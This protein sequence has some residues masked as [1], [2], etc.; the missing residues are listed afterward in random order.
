MLFTVYL[1]G[2][3]A[4]AI[5]TRHFLATVAAAY[6]VPVT[7][8]DAV[9]GLLGSR[10]VVAYAVLPVATWC[11]VR[12]LQDEARHD[13]LVRYAT[14]TDWAFGQGRRALSWIGLLVGALVC[15]AL[16]SGVG[17]PFGW[18]WS[19]A[20]LE[21]EIVRQLPEIGARLPLP[22]LGVALHALALV[23]TLVALTILAAGPASKLA[24]PSVLIG[25]PVAV[26]L[27]AM[28]SS[29]T[30][31]WVAAVLGPLTYA[32]PMRAALLLPF[33]VGGGVIIL[34]VALLLGY[35]LL[36]A[37]EMREPRREGVPWVASCF[38]AGCATLLAVAALMPPGE[39]GSVASTL[40]LLQGVGTD[41]FSLVHYLANIVVTL[42]PAVVLHRGL[43]E[44]LTE[45]RIMEMSRV[46]TPGRW[47]LRRLRDAAVL[48]GTYGL[49][50]AMWATVLAAADARRLPGPDVVT[51]TGLW[52]AAVALQACVITV[53]LALATTL[54]R[55]AEGAAYA[56]MAIMVL[57]LPLGVLSRWSPA[58]QASLGRLAE[59]DD[60]GTTSAE[61]GTLL[62]LTAW[63]VLLATATIFLF[64]RTRGEIT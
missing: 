49:A 16:I 23:A 8:W 30:E 39:R 56:C 6:A 26:L 63:I 38:A 14:R 17:L 37:I 29:Q 61:P 40:Y 32:L 47:Y 41:G 28:I 13:F 45:R 58:G 57:S 27:W 43:V 59:L 42:A 11:V 25:V 15:V 7:Y 9:N 53:L 21:P 46:G 12:Q 3:V 34:A 5:Y 55:R 24:R 35:H 33:G 64:N 19:P 10:Y 2:L 60:Y 48:C 51:L 54:A 44:A 1:V 36:L 62:V 22:V 52:G 20:S 31:G 50:L 18:S 4:Y